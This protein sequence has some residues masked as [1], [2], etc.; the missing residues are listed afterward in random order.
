M[1]VAVL[2]SGRA[3]S[4]A[5]GAHPTTV[6]R[7]APGPNPQ[8][9]AF[10]FSCNFQGHA[11]TA[12]SERVFGKD[13]E[14]MELVTGATG[15]VGRAAAAPAGRRRPPRAR[16]GAPARAVEAL[17]GVEA[18]RGRP[19]HRRR[20]RPRRSRGSRPPTTSCTRWRPAPATAPFADRDRRAAERVRQRRRRGRRGADRL[21]RRDRAA[22]R[23]ALPAPQLAPR[24]RAHPARSRAGLDRA[25]GVDRDRRRLVL[26]PHARAPGRAA[27]RAADAR[28]ARQPHPA[29]RRARRD[30]V[31]RPHAG[32]AGR[33]GTVPGRRRARTCSPTPR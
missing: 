6:G 3:S 20:P 12:R 18:V 28:L 32:G 1:E 13:A 19:A 24:G 5:S 33:G 29:D 11:P 10:S 14:R 23:G 17:A 22:G 2:R 16:A 8:I 7:R 21:P 26:V 4:S 25:A 15:Y 30:R 27:A 31:P 9:G